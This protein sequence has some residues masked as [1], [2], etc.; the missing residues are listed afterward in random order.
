M[1]RDLEPIRK[2]WLNDSPL[3]EKLVKYVKPNVERLL[4]EAGIWNRV[5]GRHKDLDSLLKKCLRRPELEYG[6]I[7]DKAG[8]RIVTRFLE[9][10]PPVCKLIEDNFEVKKKEDFTASLGTEKFGYQGIHLDVA[11]RNDDQEAR[12]FGE[13]VIEFQL[14]TLSQHLWCEMAHELN[15]KPEFAVPKSIDRRVN[16]LS[17]LI[18]TCDRE[19]SLINKE[20]MQLPDAQPL[21]VLAAL[22]KQFYRVSA[23]HYDRELSLDVIRNLLPLYSK[24][25]GWLESHFE[26][27][28][29]REQTKINRLHLLYV[30]TPT[31]SIFLYQPEALM[32]FDLLEKDPFVLKDAWIQHFPER[33]LERLAVAWGAPLP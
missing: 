9:N 18:E 22:E 15:Y 5:D 11:L 30:D 24:E 6:L 7:S 25:V 3:Y 27:F 4:R 10:L 1:I 29:T 32:I 19:F 28:Y 2:A 23:K 14:R 13:R 8:I 17:A 21:M 33:E 26:E 31:R 16:C 12:T 20:I